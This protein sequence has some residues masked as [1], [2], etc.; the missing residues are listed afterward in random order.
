MDD[1]GCMCEKCNCKSSALLVTSVCDSCLSG[2]HTE[3]SDLV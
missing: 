1:I 3:K 2:N